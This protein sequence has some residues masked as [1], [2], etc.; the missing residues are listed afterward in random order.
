M[1]ESSNLAEVM[2]A[3]TQNEAAT[4]EVVKPSLKSVKSKK[5]AP[6]KKAKTAKPKSEAKEIFESEKSQSET[7]SEK[8]AEQAK[9]EVKAPSSDNAKNKKPSQLKKNTST[10][11]NR[12]TRQEM[13]ERQANPTSKF[14]GR[15]KTMMLGFEYRSDILHEYL[16]LNQ[17]TMLSAY[18]RMAALLRMVAN[19]KTCHQHVTLWITQNVTICDR[20]VK[21]LQAQREAIIADTGADDLEM[22]INIPDDYKTTFEASHPIA[23]K[24]LAVLRLVDNELNES[25]VLYLAGVIDDESY[26]K[27]RSQ[28]TTVVRG[29]VDRIYKATT[30]GVRAGGRYAPQQLAQWLR[31]GNKLMFA[32]LPLQ[33]EHLATEVLQ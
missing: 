18:E 3:E 24:M 33:Y 20:Q 31:D 5:S 16:Q 13:I 10:R 26:N 12:P 7:L 6:V 4:P 28:A 15:Q 9:D 27:L 14:A 22:N 23:H 2:T 21:E 29:S 8:T 11:R 1:S 32:D 17:S 25:E 30:P 19:D